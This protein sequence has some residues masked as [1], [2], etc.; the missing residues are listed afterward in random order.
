MEAAP[1]TA[2]LE[3]I[4]EGAKQQVMKLPGGLA[5]PEAVMGGPQHMGIRAATVTSQVSECLSSCLHHPAAHCYLCTFSENLHA[6]LSLC[7]SVSVQNDEDDMGCTYAELSLFGRL[8]KMA[9]AG[10]VSMYRAALGHWQGT[11]SPTAVAEKVRSAPG[12]MHA[13][14]YTHS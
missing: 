7:D 8:R 3:P 1:P 13:S 9:R 12:F 5:G 10:P 14:I 6:F 2:E 4:V 11:L